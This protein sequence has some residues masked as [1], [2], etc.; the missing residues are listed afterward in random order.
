M[1]E[2]SRPPQLPSIGPIRRTRVGTWLVFLLL[3]PTLMAAATEPR[4]E[5]ALFDRVNL[6]PAFFEE[7]SG[8]LARVLPARE[9]EFVW[10]PA[11]DQLAVYSP[12]GEIQLILS[13]SPPEVWGFDESIM[14]AVLSPKRQVPGGVIVVFPARVARVVGARR[15]RNFSDRTPRDSRLARAVGRVIAHEV[16]HVVAPDHRHGD[17]GIMQENQSRTSLLAPE[18]RLDP[19]CTAIFQARLPEYLL[20]VDRLAAATSPDEESAVSSTPE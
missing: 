18:S 11:N 3:V 17:E 9:V 13:P 19:A 16:V 1:S 15:Y 5:L 12:Q 14:A 2:A 7:M 6:S 10:L 4:F 8:E 20:A